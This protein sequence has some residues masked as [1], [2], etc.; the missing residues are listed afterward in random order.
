MYSAFSEAIF[1]S[2]YLDFPTRW[3]TYKNFIIELNIPV[4]F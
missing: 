1:P 4:F 3:A 2:I